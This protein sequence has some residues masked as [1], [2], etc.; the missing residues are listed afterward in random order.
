MTPRAVAVTVLAALLAVAALV[1][2]AVLWP[3]G[4]PAGAPA[5]V[6]RGFGV[7]EVELPDGRQVTCVTWRSASGRAGGVDCDWE[8]AR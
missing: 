7:A 6:D 2:V 1:A 3:S 4:S 5:Q 8:R